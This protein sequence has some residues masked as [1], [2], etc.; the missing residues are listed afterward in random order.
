MYNPTFF[1]IVTSCC[2]EVYC[3]YSSR[4]NKPL[5]DIKPIGNEGFYRCQISTNNRFNIMRNKSTIL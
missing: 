4:K 3:Y 2:Y 1:S 5:Y